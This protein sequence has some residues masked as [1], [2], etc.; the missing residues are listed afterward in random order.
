MVDNAEY[1]ELMQAFEH[2]RASMDGE[3]EPGATPVEHGEGLAQ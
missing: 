1:R 3:H 2:D